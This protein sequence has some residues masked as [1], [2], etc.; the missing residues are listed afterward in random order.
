M[1]SNGHQDFE[2]NLSKVMQ[3][4]SN[5]KATQVWWAQRLTAIALIPLVFWFVFFVVK[6][7]LINK[8]ENF[9]EVIS[10]FNAVFLVMFIGFGIYH[11][12]LGIV[13]I[14]ED[15]IHCRALRVSLLIFLKLF[16][17]LT[18]ITGISAILVI[19]I[20]MFS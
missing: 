8:G 3:L 19:Y 16:S 11:G 2:S 13:D 5:K 12:F 7:V 1:L 18:A 15:Y 4:G 17:V 20:S 10:P 6:L 14:I 9:A